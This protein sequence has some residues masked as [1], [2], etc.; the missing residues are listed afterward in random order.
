[1][2][3]ITSTLGILHAAGR[4]EG[5]SRERG[6]DEVTD[7]RLARCPLPY[8]RILPRDESSHRTG[9]QQ[10]V[11]GGVTI[12]AVPRYHTVSTDRRPRP[13]GRRFRQ[14]GRDGSR[15]VGEHSGAQGR[16]PSPAGI[17]TLRSRREGTAV[18]HPERPAAFSDG[19]FWRGPIVDAD[20][21]PRPTGVRDIHPEPIDREASHY[22]YRIYVNSVVSTTSLKDYP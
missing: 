1:M 11:P 7:S 3:R 16:R 9:P 21:H 19:D 12:P 5:S 15:A 10:E 4:H 6:R 2:V 14:P 17:R 13:S 8:A 22:Y 18:P 20:L